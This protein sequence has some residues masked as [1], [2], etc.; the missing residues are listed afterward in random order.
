MSDHLEKRGTKRKFDDDVI[1][2]DKVYVASD[3]Y[4]KVEQDYKRLKMTFDEFSFQKYFD[5]KDKCDQLEGDYKKMGDQVI[6]LKEKYDQLGKD[7]KKVVDAYDSLKD[8][9][10]KLE[11]ESKD[12][13]IPDSED[14]SKSVILPVKTITSSTRVVKIGKEDYTF[15]E[16]DFKRYNET[17]DFNEKIRILFKTMGFSI[18]GCIDNTKGRAKGSDLEKWPKDKVTALIKYICGDIN[19]KTEYY[20]RSEDIEKYMGSFAV[21]RRQIEKRKVK[22]DDGGEYKE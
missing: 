21:Q 7:S 15:L 14:E 16:R 4:D 19:N 3:H 2:Q 6:D 8:K 17:T 13:V 1:F 18:N 11:K 5:L 9:Y 12:W 10:D 22:E 20:G